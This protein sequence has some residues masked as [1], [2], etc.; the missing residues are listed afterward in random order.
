M[1]IQI[2]VAEQ[3]LAQMQAIVIAHVKEGLNL[4][5]LL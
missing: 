5:I 2:Q 1:A 4:H 3:V